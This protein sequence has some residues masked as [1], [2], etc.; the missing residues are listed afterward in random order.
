VL[1]GPFTFVGTSVEGGTVQLRYRI[2]D[3]LSFTEVVELGV[4]LP[5]TSAVARAVHV[6]HL[7]AGVS[8]YKCVAPALLVLPPVTADERALVEA[9]YD[10]GLREFAYRNGLAVPLAVEIAGDPA[11][12][13]P[14]PGSAGPA[15]A[16]ALVPI[17]GGKD[18]ALVAAL[19]PDGQLFA[20][21]PVGAHRHLAAALDRPLLGARRTLDPQLRELVARGVPNGH[22]PVTAITSAISVLAALA[23]GRYDVLMG[24]ERS[25]DEASLVTPDGVAV[26][27]QFSKSVEAEGLLRAAFTPTGVRYLSLLRPLSEL[28]IGAGVARRG[29]AADI[30]SCNRVFTVWNENRSSR[31]QRP[32]GEC[33]KCLFTALMLAPSS[34]PAAIEAQ[35]G[36]ALLDDAAHIAP[37]R[38]LWSTVKP[39]DCVG[40]R[41]ETAAAVVLLHR[42]DGWRHQVVVRALAQESQA[43]LDEAG[44]DPTEFLRIGPLEDLP[45]EY[46]EALAGLSPDLA[47]VPGLSPASS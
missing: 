29:L 36:R 16:G 45:A 27:H 3:D 5:N 25:A 33:A 23:L 21:N 15:G 11:S 34:S 14:V 20:V 39:F 9:L 40:E 28:A 46:R 37:T 42:T 12:D 10:Q 18:S 17:G 44:I 35:Y 4:D 1:T 31:E 13:L 6:L 2:G 7:A 43:M 26:N 32:C 24:I 8:Y 19:V 30:V 47:A 22:V 41:L 38:D